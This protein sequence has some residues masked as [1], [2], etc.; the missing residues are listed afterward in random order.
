MTDVPLD[1]AIVGRNNIGES[2][3][4]AYR[5]LREPLR[6][7]AYVLVNDSSVAEEIVQ[8]AFVRFFRHRHRVTSPEAFLRATVINGCRNHHRWVAVRRRFLAMG[9]DSAPEPDHLVDAIARLP[10]RQRAV[11]VL[12]YYEALPEREIAEA[13]QMPLGTVK[14]TLHRALAQLRRSIDDH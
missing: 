12:R 1:P 6:R 11:V 2:F 5:R 3:D 9:A 7:L 13:L 14:S 8:D 10:Y 4:T